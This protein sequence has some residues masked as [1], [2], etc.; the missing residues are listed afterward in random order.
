LIEAAEIPGI[1]VAWIEEGQVAWTGAFGVRDAATGALV[2]KTTIFEAASLS[3]PVFAYAVLRLVARGELDLDAPLWDSEGYERLA[4]DERAREITA[5]TVL[6]HTTGLP[7]WGGTPLEFNRDP[8][9]VWGYSGEGFVFLARLLERRTGLSLNQLV[10]REVFVPLDMRHSSFVWQPVYDSTAAVPHDLL[11]RAQPKRQPTEGNAAASLHTTAVD[12]ARFVSA[13]LAGEGLPPDLA[14]QM[15]TPAVQ[16]RDWGPEE[17]FPYLSWGLGWGV[18]RSDQGDAIWHWGDNGNFRCFVIAYPERRGGL[19]YFTNSNSGLAIADDLVSLALPDTHWA[20][21]WLEYW[22]WD[23]PQRLARIELRR[24]F[25]N[26]EAENAWKRYAEWHTKHPE[27]VGAAELGNLGEFLMDEGRTQVGMEVLE[28]RV[29]DFPSAA[30][31]I[32]LAEAKT[33]VGAYEDALADYR[34]A[35]A[36]DP[37]EAADLEPRL[38]WLRE[39]I[40]A[41]AD[42]VRLSTAQLQGYVGQYGPRRIT[43]EEGNLIYAR[44][45]ATSATRLVPLTA[46]LFGLES[47][48]GFRIRFERDA[49]GRVAKIIGLYSDGRRDE[50]SRSN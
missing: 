14:D 49:D 27:E 31:W 16:V 12:Y 3:K 26:E 39:G 32:D 33:E 25:L 30:A 10:A 34:R 36:L 42:P 11:A 23:E 2:T 24:A 18:Q 43:L 4:H 21:R 9:T 15:L 46:S 28:R 7:N 5:R 17:T 20:I 22:K 40:K 37:E 19:V 48:K 47:N 44:D 38:E 8:G 41:A 6:T 13:V 1:S 50:T 29:A 35:S 45:G